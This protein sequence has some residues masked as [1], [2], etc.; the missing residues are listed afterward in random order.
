MPRSAPRSALRTF[1]VALAAFFLAMP[2]SNLEGSARAGEDLSGTYVMLQQATTVTELP[3]VK[4]VVSKMRSTALLRLDHQGQVISG[5]GEL[6][7]LHIESSSDMISTSFPEAFRKALS[8][9]RFRALLEGEGPQ[10]TLSQP[11]QTDVL[12]A[13]LKKPRQE[14]LPTDAN[15]TRVY[16]Q[17]HD[18][19]PGLT[20]RIDGFVS[21]EVYVVQRTR[22]QFSGRRQGSGF[23]GKL[24]VRNEQHVVGASSR[25]LNRSPNPKPVPAQ[26]YFRL[27]KVSSGLS[28]S[29]GARL[30][31]TFR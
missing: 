1:H 28:C 29:E 10:M 7:D 15:D 26:S 17:D 3:V 23:R 11:E 2:G 8:P 31:H 13:R 24:K 22:S 9:V 5:Q 25:I 30:A 20:V 4:D 16:D 6:C 14:S 27:E 12:G 18:G 19:H 21:G